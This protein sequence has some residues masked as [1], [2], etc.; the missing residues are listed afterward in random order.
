V[1]EPPGFP[2]WS[3]VVDGGAAMAGG[4]EIKTQKQ[5]IKLYR[6]R[7]ELTEGQ[8]AVVLNLP[9]VGL[10]VL[11]IAY[12]LLYTVRLSF[13]EATLSSLR[14]NTV[15]FAGF[16]NYITIM[17]DDLF[18]TTLLRTFVFG[19][20]S[21]FLMISVGLFVALAMNRSNVW[22][23]RITRMFILLPWAVPA[24]ANGVMW[25]FIF[26]PRYGHLNALLLGLGIIDS[27]LSY[28]GQ[29]LPAMI[30][31]IIAYVWRVFPF[32]ALL[33]HAAL[34]N[35][36]MELYEA[37]EVDG[38]TKWQQ[39]WR[40]TLPMLRPVIAVLLIMR[41]AFALTIFDEVF[42][43]TRGGPGTST[44]TSAWYSYFTTFDR[45]RFDL[46]GTSALILSLVIFALAYIYIRFVYRQEG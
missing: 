44:W 3:P 46:G 41:T 1:I 5:Y 17:Q 45:L 4:A 11:L 30:S 2:Q 21:V 33:F 20:V 24:I 35:I 9:V 16:R 23:S 14:N 13:S 39:F 7:R 32:C 34:Q 26:N 6:S 31:V 18:M 43:L 28:L 27:P 37:A 8:L 19:A 38:A 29:P 22:I 15:S 25:S 40:V 42:A 10:L 12:P 36:P